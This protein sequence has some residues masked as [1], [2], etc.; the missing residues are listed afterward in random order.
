MSARRL[1]LGARSRCGI[2]E[3]T[4]L[5]DHSGRSI[6]LL[7]WALANRNAVSAPVLPC[8]WRLSRLAEMPNLYS[9][10][11]GGPLETDDP[12]PA[13]RSCNVFARRRASLR[14]V[15]EYLEAAFKP[16]GLPAR[17]GTCDKVVLHDV[18]LTHITL[19]VIIHRRTPTRRARR[20]KCDL[21]Q[22]RCNRSDL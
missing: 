8:L 19:S 11:Q 12:R 6:A 3:I 10:M 21:F 14:W 1:V 16:I 13:C 5:A 4:V 20:A 2:F 22:G 17:T 18:L 9:T 7:D 15:A